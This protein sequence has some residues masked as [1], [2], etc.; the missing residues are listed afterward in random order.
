MKKNMRNVP[1]LLF[2]FCTINWAES[3]P[4]ERTISEKEKKIT[5]ME[6]QLDS[7]FVSRMK[8][9]NQAEIIAYRIELY[10]TKKALNAKEHGNLEKQLQESQRL[11]NQMR[12]IGA[13][14]EKL[15]ENRRQ[16]IEAVVTDY[17][18]EIDRLIQI[19]ENRAPLDKQEL[20]E[21]IRSCLEKKQTWETQLASFIPPIQPNPSVE[22]QPWDTPQ[23]L[24]M[25]GDLLLDREDALRREIRLVDDRIHALKE[26]KKMRTKLAELTNDL[27]LFDEREELLGGSTKNLRNEENY[28]TYWNMPDGSIA[29]GSKGNL[30]EIRN[31]D[32]TEQSL[33]RNSF[34][35]ISGTMPRSPKRIEESIEQLEKFRNRMIARADSLNKRAQ[36]FYTE[37]QKP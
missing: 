11:E 36:W 34:I 32:I 25:K 17:Q 10:R 14:M 23:D 2:L 26:E 8:L 28:T 20:F 7:L 4:Q 29:S 24:R 21:K 33:S 19:K 30:N 16:T 3:L 13:Q 15:Q 27:D 1:L 12:E 5:V 35:D 22:S 37:A 18:S 6:T 31:P 9:L